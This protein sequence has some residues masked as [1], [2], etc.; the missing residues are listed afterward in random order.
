[1]ALALLAV[2]VVCAVPA[3]AA[4][5]DKRTFDAVQPPEGDANTPPRDADRQQ[6]GGAQTAPMPKDAMPVA[7]QVSDPREAG[8]NQGVKQAPSQQAAPE[9]GGAQ[10]QNAAPNAGPPAPAGP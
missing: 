4:E 1:M 3:Q 5:G 8:G 2:F 10:P 7:P 6:S 9:G